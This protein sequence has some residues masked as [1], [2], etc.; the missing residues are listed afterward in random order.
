MISLPKTMSV[1]VK[2]RVI[3]VLLFFC[4]VVMASVA[5]IALSRTQAVTQEVVR[6]SAALSLVQTA[7]RMRDELRAGVY[8]SLLVGQIAGPSA[9]DVRKDARQ[10]ALTLRETMTRLAALDVEAELRAEVLSNRALVDRYLDSAEAMITLALADRRAAQA[11][12]PAFNAA[13]NELLGAFAR[14]TEA[15]RQLNQGAVVHAEALEINA[16]L[17][18]AGTALLGLVLMAIVVQWMGQSIRSSLHKLRSAASAVAC[19][20]LDRRAEIEAD[21]EVGR[22]GGAVNAMADKLQDMLGQALQDSERHSFNHKLSEALEMADSEAD[23]YL[24]IQRAMA[25]VAPDRPME[26]LV[27]DSSQAVLQRATE[28]PSAGAPGCNV[29][30]PFSCQAVRRGSSVSFPDSEAINACQRLRGRPGAEGAISAVCVPLHFMGRALGVLHSTG[31]MNQVQMAQL[32]SIGGQAAARIG[33]VR[34]FERTQLQAATDA[35]TGLANRRAL[36]AAIQ[37]LMR[38]QQPFAL[39]M[40]DLDKFKMLNDTYGHLVG[41]EALRLFA[42]TMKKSVRDHDIVARW[43]GEEFALVLTGSTAR[44]GF[45]WAGRARTRLA[46]ALEGSK[47]PKFTVSFGISDSTMAIRLED[48][49][50]IA[51]EALYRS[52][53]Q[54]RDRATQGEAPAANE[55]IARERSEH[56]AKTDLTRLNAAA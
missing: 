51:D 56:E 53:E 49:L 32:T 48:L 46:K 12:L 39:V 37:E 36:E 47:V 18:V 27:A 2:L 23:A 42:D 33:V 25:V 20:D 43:G 22:L 50:R 55:P 52:K 17:A 16:N 11:A 5:A 54:G 24:V 38:K 28:H 30:S 29:D 21:D 4:L 6:Q 9:D 41:D 45:D 14:Q 13:F 1:Q 34:A 26:L 3:S 10:S 44:Q 7:N 35:G 8:S 31:P 15:L 40:A 19:G